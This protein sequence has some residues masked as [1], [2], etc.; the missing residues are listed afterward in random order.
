VKILITGTAG[1]LGRCLARV[2][3]SQELVALGHAALDVTRLDAVRNA[4]WLHRPAL[5]I[6]ASAF[7]DV[8]SA[9]S[10]SDEA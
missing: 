6:N 10:R 8:D 3:A 4:V 5:V 9:E 2:L 1:Q 7:N